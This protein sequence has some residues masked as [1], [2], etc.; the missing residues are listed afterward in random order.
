VSRH[1]R[2]REIL[3][4]V[5][6]LALL[7]N[8][9]DGDDRAA[10][11]RVEEVR[12]LVD[13]AAD[14]VYGRGEDVPELDVVAGYAAWSAT[15]DRPGNPLIAVEQPVVWSLLDRWSPGRTLDAACGTGRH[16]RRLVELGHQVV[17]VDATPEMLE[18]ARAAAPRA[19]FEL[20]DLT[21]LPVESG[22]VDQAVCSLALDHAPDL[23]P[24]LAELARVVRPGGRIVISDVHPALSILGVAAFFRAADGSSAFVRNHRHLHGEYLDAFARVGLEVRRCLEPRF[25][26]EEVALQPVAMAFAPEA[27]SAAYLGMPGA[28]VWDLLCR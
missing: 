23:V 15:Y 19:R 21:D 20:G 16:T 5:E 6:G 26:P 10:Q 8:L 25:G 28:L 27:A 2:L 14:A 22:A 13:T 24:P 18:L 7:R 9:F 1:V 4:G 12:R 17:G 3:V 11:A